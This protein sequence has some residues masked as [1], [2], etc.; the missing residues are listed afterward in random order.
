M[1]KVC[2]AVIAVSISKLMVWFEAR[3]GAEFDNVSLALVID[4][5][6]ALRKS[7]GRPVLHRKSA[8]A[9]VI[10]TACRV[11]TVFAVWIIGFTLYYLSTSTLI[12]RDTKCCA[13][14]A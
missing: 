9:T 2:P 13:L 12:M 11:P 6:S 5:A 14:S 8:T 7:V 10:A 4:A 1:S 3:L